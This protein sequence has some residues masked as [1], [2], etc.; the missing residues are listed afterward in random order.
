MID[1]LVQHPEVLTLSGDSYRARAG[2]EL[3]AK[4]RASSE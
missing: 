4:D 1:R 2:R 3:F